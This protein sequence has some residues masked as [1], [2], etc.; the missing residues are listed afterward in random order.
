MKRYR[1]EDEGMFSWQEE[2][3][4]I[5]H[6]RQAEQ[7]R[8]RDAWDQAQRYCEP[9]TLIAIRQIVREEIERA[10]DARTPTETPSQER[11]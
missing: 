1:R 7:R 2:M 10:L 4:R 5:M 3:Q 9:V 8:M 11:R 6:E